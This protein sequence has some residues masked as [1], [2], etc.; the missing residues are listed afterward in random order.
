MATI[1]TVKTATTS[2]MMKMPF[3]AFTVPN[4][5]GTR[6]ATAAKMISDMPLPMPRWVMSSPIHISSTAPAVRLPAQSRMRGRVKLPGPNRSMPCT[7]E[8]KKPPPPLCSMY[9]RVIDC[10]RAIDTIT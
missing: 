5:E 4:S 1:I 7:P 3:S 9:V 10:T 6:L 8:A 2:S